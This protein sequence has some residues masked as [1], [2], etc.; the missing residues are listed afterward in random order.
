MPVQMAPPPQP[1]RAEAQ[2]SDPDA[3][4]P[5]HV[6][7]QRLEH[8]PDLTTAPLAQNDL[9]LPGIS[10]SGR[11]VDALGPQPL[12]IGL[13]PRLKPRTLRRIQRPVGPD[14]VDLL[15]VVPG[16]RQK[17][18]ECAVV[19]Q[20][21]QPFTVP[22]EPTDGIDAAGQ[23]VDERAERSPPLGVIARADNV[24]RLVEE[25]IDQRLARHDLSVEGD[26]V[27][28]RVDAHPLPRDGRAID[29]DTTRR[30]DG[31]ARATGSDAA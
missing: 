17:M 28:G 12:A 20:N 29:A 7:P 10:V 14:A 3:L 24:A 2:G 27:C 4:E 30:D 9:V 23:A 18:R 25:D 31:L 26:R 16:V 22:V 19:R 8:P 6:H 5:K 1:H 13:N 21:Q 15:D 11:R